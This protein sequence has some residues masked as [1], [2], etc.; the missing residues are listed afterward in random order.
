[1]TW[2]TWQRCGLSLALL[3]GLSGCAGVYRVDNQVESFARWSEAATPSGDAKTSSSAVPAP[4]Q[5]YR[6]ERLPSQD[7]GP[8][9][10]PQ[11][12]LEQLAQSALAPLR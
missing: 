7:S 8:G 9:A 11:A 10:Q 1:M 4:P 5:H 3:V 6:F 12:E 2:T